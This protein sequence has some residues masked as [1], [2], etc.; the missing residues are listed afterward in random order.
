MPVLTPRTRAGSGLRRPPH[1]VVIREGH[2]SGVRKTSLQHQGY[3]GGASEDSI[4]GY[5]VTA[6]PPLPAPGPWGGRSAAT[7]VQGRCRCS[8]ACRCSSY[9]PM[10]S[11]MAPDS[12]P[13]TGFDRTSGSRCDSRTSIATPSAA[14][15]EPLIPNVA[16][17]HVPPSV[18][19]SAEASPSRRQRTLP[20]CKETFTDELALGSGDAG[21]LATSIPME[22]DG[23]AAGGRASYLS[24]VYAKHELSYLAKRVDEI[25]RYFI[26]LEGMIGTGAFGPVLEKTLRE[27][28]AKVGHA[29]DIEDA[30]EA[31]G[32]LD[33]AIRLGLGPKR[34]APL[35]KRLEWLENGP[36]RIRLRAEIASDTLLQHDAASLQ[37]LIDDAVRLGL[38]S[39]EVAVV[40]RRLEEVNQSELNEEFL[41]AAAHGNVHVAER[42]IWKG[43][44]REAHSMA[45]GLTVWHFAAQAGDFELASLARR[46]GAN[47]DILDSFGRSPLMVAAASGHVGLVQEILSL[48]V[49]VNRRATVISDTC[50]S[51]GADDEVCSGVVPCGGTALHAALLRTGGEGT[52]VPVV[53]ALLNRGADAS[54]VDDHGRAPLWYAARGGQ[55]GEARL[56]LRAGAAAA[57]HGN[58]L[59][60]SAL[61]AAAHSHS[62]MVANGDVEVARRLEEV[63]RLL[64]RSGAGVDIKEASVARA[65]FGDGF[66]EACAEGV[67]LKEALELTGGSPEETATEAARKLA[68]KCASR[69]QR[70]GQALG[71]PAEAAAFAAEIRPAFEALVFRL[72]VSTA[73]RA[74][75]APVPSEV[76][77]W[78]LARLSGLVQE[79]ATEGS[80]DWRSVA[81]SVQ[82]RLHFSNATG[83]YRALA[84][85]EAQNSHRLRGVRDHL[86]SGGCGIDVFL[87]VRGAVCLLTLCVA[88]CVEVQDAEFGRATWLRDELRSAM[89]RRSISEVREALDFA[90]E[91]LE[92][93]R[94]SA[95]LNSSLSADD[96]PALV[97][98]VKAGDIQILHLLLDRGAAPNAQDKSGVS[99]LELAAHRQD[100]RSFEMLL[101]AGADTDDT[102]HLPSELRFTIALDKERSGVSDDFAHEARALLLEARTQRGVD[103]FLLVELIETFDGSPSTFASIARLL[104]TG[105]DPNARTRGSPTGKPLPLLACAVLHRSMPLAR[106]LLRK[107]AL[108]QA[109]D[110]ASSSALLLAANSPLEPL[111]LTQAHEEL[112]LAVQSCR[113][114][115][116]RGL[117]AAGVDPEASITVPSGLTGTLLTFAAELP[118]EDGIPL[119]EDLLHRGASLERRDTSGRNA[120]MLLIRNGAPMSSIELMI[121]RGAD[122]GATDSAGQTAAMIAATLG[123]APTLQLLLEA[124]ASGSAQDLEAVDVP[125]HAL[126]A[127]QGECLALLE[128]RGFFLTGRATLAELLPSVRSG[129]ALRVARLLELASRSHPEIANSEV[130]SQSPEAKP[131][132]SRNAAGSL[133]AEAVRIRSP[134]IVTLLLQRG[135]RLHPRLGIGRPAFGM[136]E[137]ED[138]SV[139][140]M[141][142]QDMALQAE[143]RK[144]LPRELFKIA[145]ETDEVALENILM[146]EAAGF[147]I[148]PRDLE[149]VGDDGFNAL[150]HAIVQGNVVLELAILARGARFCAASSLPAALMEPAKSG[151]IDAVKR[152]LAAGAD[153]TAQDDRGMTPLDWA[154]LTGVMGGVVWRC[155]EKAM[156][157]HED[158]QYGSEASQPG[159]KRASSKGDPIGRDSKHSLECIG[160]LQQEVP[161]SLNSIARGGGG[162]GGAAPSTSGRSIGSRGASCFSGRGRS[163]RGANT[164]RSSPGSA[165]QSVEV[166]DP[167]KF[168]GQIEAL[169]IEAGGR[170]G[171]TTKSSQLALRAPLERR[172]YETVHRRIIGGAD[173]S[174]P[175]EKG[176]GLAHVA[177]D[178]GNTHLA[179]VFLEAGASPDVRDRTGRTVLW[180]AIEAKQAE[181]VE[182]CMHANVDLSLGLG[183]K[184]DGSVAH[185]ALETNQEAL[186]VRCLESPSG[187]GQDRVD[188]HGRTVLFRA[189]ELG[190]VT[191][192]RI[193]LAL[194]ADAQV[195]DK[196][197]GRGTLHAALAARQAA[198]M[199]DLLRARASVDATD[200][201]GQSPLMLAAVNGDDQGV[202]ILLEAGA[203][204]SGAAGGAEALAAIGSALFDGAT[205][206][207]Q[208]S[209]AASREDLEQIASG[210]ELKKACDA[211]AGAGGVRRATNPSS[212][213]AKAEP[214]TLLTMACLAA[215]AARDLGAD[216]VDEA[217]GIAEASSERAAR[218]AAAHLAALLACPLV[219]G[220]ALGRLA[221]SLVSWAATGSSPAVRKARGAALELLPLALL[222]HGARA[223]AD[224]LQHASV[225]PDV[226]QDLLA[227]SG[228]PEPSAATG[229]PK[230][231]APASD[232]AM[233]APAGFLPPLWAPVA[234]SP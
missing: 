138:S 177:L 142:G 112:Q 94:L 53:Q 97:V 209:P 70:Q 218:A 217:R 194:G 6:P 36:R 20:I 215:G 202:D 181:V 131:P 140:L 197:S 115:V 110:G 27:V 76:R 234:P 231:A 15:W 68:T 152:R 137:Q 19:I 139:W 74:T 211:L 214:P 23:T 190:H 38:P 114:D 49:D 31:Q 225:P 61:V 117:L 229:L 25:A 39:G 93:L 116:V 40:R 226:V 150:D 51:R 228:A 87:E 232:I 136:A 109:C 102:M 79:S 216:V 42:L 28:E 88:R 182:A 185:L 14:F 72:A 83:V 146:D 32:F 17:E 119:I 221:R 86:V 58:S 130:G 118:H 210:R 105:T 103:G 71:S 95:A 167:R 66:A 191:A 188:S 45:A 92:S 174:V 107:G 201:R 24:H 135:A 145:M 2:G 13:G 171:S 196:I 101:R 16:S 78:R 113:V 219:A 106:L 186:V 222:Q 127:L 44:D 18:G 173:C 144:A 179:V 163:C 121:G 33:A 203:R 164:R 155:V 148:G 165:A 180:R 89:S 85:M 159:S 10:P 77:M 29:G 166:A 169:I 37:Q 12:R 9:S 59:S 193:C 199:P 157:R 223:A 233:E 7:Q 35:K 213:R 122:V 120:L 64:L 63:C 189:I 4:L 80:V 176:L 81:D 154:V 48:G 168:Y 204:P 187:V 67:S 227:L 84:T 50:S 96:P 57:A 46:V 34:Y 62:C 90:D 207:T 224:S 162:G 128:D 195:V 100:L 175:G 126:R 147:S 170:L 52:Q 141:A 30:E 43:A 172:D 56:L 111:L 183:A 149:F 151:D 41:Q 208:A 156:F 132:P 26:A 200:R 184:N 1:I 8:S 82:G 230:E 104:E 75:V 22:G 161:G 99:A 220:S 55:V 158:T 198:V 212:T 98:A 125:W 21:D 47:A 73:G 3:L 192:A 153:A 160:E 11:T 60:T 134:E 65:A 123:Q 129:D 206:I 133:L 91:H 124:G 143:L 108:L 205:R 54:I 69:S 178:F 5:A